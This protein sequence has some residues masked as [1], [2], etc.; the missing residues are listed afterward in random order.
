M[1]SEH[2]P[3]LTVV[4]DLHG[5]M[6]TRRQHA[7]AVLGG[8]EVRVGHGAYVPI[9]VWERSDQ[10]ARH[11]LRL[12]AFARTRSRVPVFSH[13]SAAVLHDLPIVG[14][15]PDRIHVSV[16]RT[17]GGRSARCQSINAVR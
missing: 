8:T 17:S 7:R 3:P 11:L 15:F 5:R 14:P 12:R 13:W 16:G 4:R 9:D 10:R 2:Q 6:E 1:D